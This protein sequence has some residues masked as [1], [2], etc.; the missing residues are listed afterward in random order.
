MEMEYSFDIWSL[1]MVLYELAM[2]EHYFEGGDN[3]KVCM[4]LK[5]SD[6][7][8]IDAVS[9]PSLKDLIGQC[10]QFNKDARPS[11]QQVKQHPFFQ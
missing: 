7:V 2:G 5:N 4:E 10:L 1:G 3:I 8:T 9:D 11:I 6:C